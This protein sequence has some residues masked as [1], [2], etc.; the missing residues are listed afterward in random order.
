MFVRVPCHVCVCHVMFVSVQ[1]LYAI[2]VSVACHIGECVMF[3]FRPAEFLHQ[4]FDSSCVGLS[5]QFQQQSVDV[6][7]L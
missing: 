6:S 1:W 3:V 5:G 2:F 7:R 4:R